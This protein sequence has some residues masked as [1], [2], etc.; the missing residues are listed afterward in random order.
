MGTQAGHNF[1]EWLR[2]AL[3]LHSAELGPSRRLLWACFWHY[4]MANAW[5]TIRREGCMVGVHHDLVCL[6]DFFSMC[7][8]HHRN[9]DIRANPGTSTC[10]GLDGD[11]HDAALAS[12]ADAQ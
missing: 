6:R 12:S 4:C 7:N 10:K 11:T 1:S 8:T 9:R 2:A 3:D 5:L